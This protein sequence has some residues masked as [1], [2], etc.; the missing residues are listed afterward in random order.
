MNIK[1]YSLYNFHAFI[2][3]MNNSRKKNVEITKNTGSDEIYAVL[4]EVESALDEDVDNEINDSDKEFFV[5]DELDYKSGSVANASDI[6]VSAANVPSPSSGSPSFNCSAHSKK[7]QPPGI[8]KALT[9]Q[10][11]KYNVTLQ[12][13]YY[14]IFLLIQGQLM[15]LRKLLI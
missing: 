1:S 7:S 9:S 10:V 4:D 15:S 3:I 2:L 6:L 13:I 5:N 11:K 8:R 12:Q 14:Y